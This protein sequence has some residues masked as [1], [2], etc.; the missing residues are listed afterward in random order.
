[1]RLLD[2]AASQGITDLEALV[3]RMRH[4]RRRRRHRRRGGVAARARR[5]ADALQGELL[6]GFAPRPPVDPSRSPLDAP[7]SPL[8]SRPPLH[9]LPSP[10]GAEPA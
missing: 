8:D 7:R 5:E 10:R 6:D 2:E 9:E 4:Q 3:D 1:V